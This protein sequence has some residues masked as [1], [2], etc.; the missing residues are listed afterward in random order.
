MSSTS[1][2]PPRA[3]AEEEMEQLQDLPDG[4][5]QISPAGSVSKGSFLASH[6]RQNSSRTNSAS[7][8]SPVMSPSDSLR[9]YVS[10]PAGS[11]SNLS[12]Q[13]YLMGQQNP[14]SRW[15]GDLGS[16]PVLN[17]RD[18]ETFV[19]NSSGHATSSVHSHSGVMTPAAG[20][21]EAPTDSYFGNAAL[22]YRKPFAQRVLRPGET[23]EKPWLEDKQRK[24]SDRKAYWIFIVGV[25]LGLIGAALLMYFAH[26]AVPR[27][28]YC[29]V[30]NEQFEGSTINKDIWFHEIESGGF[31][32]GQFEWTT[33]SSNN[34][35]VEDGK[36][37]IVPT[38]TSDALGDAAIT[39]G[40]TLNLT[41]AGACTAANKSDANCAVVSNA[42][43]GVI[44]PPIQ[45]ARLM[46]NFSR[47]IK[48]GRV[49]VKARMPTGDWIWPA[50][51][52][53]PKDSVY[54]AWPRS[55]EIDIFEGRGNVP[56]KRDSEG[57]NQMS[58][59]LHFGPNPLF[60]GYGYAT[61]LRNLWRDWFNQGSHTFG[62]EWTEDRLWT[63]E[64]SRV[65]K[66]LDVEFGDGGF[67]KR[68]RFPT[69]MANGTLLSDPWPTS[70]SQG[71]NANAA[72]FDQEFYLILNVAVGGTNGYFKDGQGDNKPWSNDA[73]N[74]A[75]QFWQ[76]K[77]RWLPSWPK[78]PKQRDDICLS[79]KLTCSLFRLHILTFADI[80]LTDDSV[81]KRCSV[82]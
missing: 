56:T 42:T 52:M 74:A 18:Y 6:S 37:Y 45:S 49:E 20:F 36:L 28:K 14:D 21:F 40:Y 1:V 43:T 77:D 34:S 29:L 27:D 30:L 55:G 25:S 39:N 23:V 81:H 3:S 38:L 76:S 67:W 57:T 41:A 82:K 78:D 12:R 9:S 61:H 31:G 63:W 50:V 73:K 48:Y 5:G 26:A 17:G 79:R 22:R 33:D 7:Q 24:S 15:T 32:N 2:L 54:G 8:I 35:F 65:F 72:P 70:S 71:T 4:S 53:M 75:G 47:S 59:T 64:H 44:L 46:T 19:A 60:D 13:V 11:M 51:W 58:S 68:G 10:S 66:N 69:Q 62:L 16:M 80:V